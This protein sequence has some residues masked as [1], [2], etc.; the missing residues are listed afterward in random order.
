MDKVI[1]I[2][3]ASGGIGASLAKQ[4]GAKGAKLVVCARRQAELD[5]VAKESGDALAVVTDVTQRA[6][7]KRVFDAAIAKHGHIDVWV[8]NAGRAISKLPSQ[9]TDE[10]LD[11][12]WRDNAK[13]AQYGVDSRKLPGAQPVDEA[14][15]AIVGAV[16]HPRA[17]VYA[18]PGMQAEVEAYLRDV[19]AAEKAAAAR[20]RRQSALGE[21]G[22][23]L[24]ASHGDDQRARGE[25][26]APRQQRV[27]RAMDGHALLR[28][29]RRDSVGS[30]FVGRRCPADR[31]HVRA[32]LEAGLRHARTERQ[33]VNPLGRELVRERF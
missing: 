9:L 22:L 24:L 7:V 33:H 19:V 8:N 32:R 31:S 1:G 30:H 6:D 20:F 27:R 28:I 3:G 21:P 15:A 25:A 23:H 29:E 13:S 16:E 2:T 26:R 12:M 11:V 18:Q 5:A 17:E 4:L 10:D 14:A